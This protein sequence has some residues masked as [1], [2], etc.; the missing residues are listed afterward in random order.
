MKMDPILI[1]S[2]MNLASTLIR[3]AIR[4]WELAGMSEEDQL[5]RFTVEYGEFKRRPASE[6]P[7]V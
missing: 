6:L 7:E 3:G 4:L 2:L 1:A 5:K